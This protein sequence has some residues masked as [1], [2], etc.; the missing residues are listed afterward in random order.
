MWCSSAVG[1]VSSW[2][3]SRWSASHKQSHKSPLVFS[4]SPGALP[5][6]F[7]IWIV[8]S[9]S[10]ILSPLLKKS[11]P[12]SPPEHSAIPGGEVVASTRCKH[13]ETERE[14]LG[15]RSY[16]K[17]G[18]REK[19]P[20]TFIKPQSVTKSGLFVCLFLRLAVKT[21]AW[22]HLRTYK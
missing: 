7:A 10:N 18:D 13:H 19:H 4:W 2:P 16:S 5:L 12:W 11:S 20:R 17:V 3:F 1:H 15:W 8:M 22:K 6:S 14:L 21:L 9:Y